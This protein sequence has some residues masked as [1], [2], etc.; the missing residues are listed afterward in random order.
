MSME[1]DTIGR[2]GMKYFGRTAAAISHE[3]KNALAIIRENAGLMNDYLAM[4]EKGMPI[5]PN[6]FKMLT[7]RIEAQTQRADTLIK[8]MNRFAHSVDDPVRTVNLNETAELLAALSHREA[9]MRQVALNVVLN[10]RPVEIATSPFLLLTLLGHCLTFALQAV[11]AGKNL[12]LNVIG[13][14]KGIGIRFEQLENLSALPP[15]HFPDAHSSALFEALG[16]A[17]DMDSGSGNLMITIKS[18]Q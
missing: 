8:N 11:G 14:D 12:T 6:K 7:G 2:A 13:S 1:L 16:A 15:D 9:A 3:L 18:I 5:D 10:Q 4:A 17:W